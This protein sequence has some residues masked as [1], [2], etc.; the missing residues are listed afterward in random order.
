MPLVISAMQE[1]KALAAMLS[2][3]YGRTPNLHLVVAAELSAFKINAG[4]YGL[5]DPMPTICDMRDVRVSWSTLL[6]SP[7]SW[8]SRSGVRSCI[9]QLNFCPM[10]E[11]VVTLL[12]FANLVQ[13]NTQSVINRLQIMEQKSALMNASVK[14]GRRLSLQP[15]S[16]LAFDE[17]VSTETLDGSE[18]KPSDEIESLSESSP[19]VEVSRSDVELV[20]VRDDLSSLM[21]Q[22]DQRRRDLASAT[23]NVILLKSS[24]SP[25]TVKQK[26]ILKKDEQALP[27]LQSALDTTQARLFDVMRALVA[28]KNDALAAADQCRLQLQRMQAAQDEPRQ[29]E[30]LRLPT[31]DRACIRYSESATRS[32]Q[33]LAE[34]EALPLEVFDFELFSDGLF[35]LKWRPQKGCFKNGKLWSGSSHESILGRMLVC[36][37]EKDKQHNFLCSDCV[38]DEAATSHFGREHVLKFRTES[39]TKGHVFAFE[40]AS[41]R[42]NCLAQFKS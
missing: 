25:L 23:S 40:T 38:V 39:D 36:S 15:E 18:A 8:D 6:L 5:V 37:Q 10:P 33:S 13:V 42:G 7:T 31:D 16:L 26:L 30:M 29:L 20:A 11:F 35:S 12:A 22:F 28:E 2:A 34:S 24:A 3:I 14:E 27:A 19:G 32:S 1:D 4:P 9:G 41:A 17:T 21:E